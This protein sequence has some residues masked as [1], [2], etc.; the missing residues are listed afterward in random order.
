MDKKNQKWSKMLKECLFSEQKHKNLMKWKS[1]DKH[2]RGLI[3]Q[4]R[5][6]KCTQPAK[7]LPINKH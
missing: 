4:R 5:A 2:K 6:E 3:E 7:E 1:A